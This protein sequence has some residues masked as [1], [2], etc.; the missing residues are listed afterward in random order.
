MITGVSQ[1]FRRAMNSGS[2]E[3]S[4]ANLDRSVEQMVEYM[5]FVDEAPLHDPVKGVSTFTETFPKRGPRDRQGRSLRD[6]DLQHR[7]FRYPLSYMIYSPIF[8]AMPAPA[9]ER[10]VRRLHEVLSGKDQSPQFAHLSA[11]DRRAI[12]EILRDTKAASF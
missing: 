12:L 10:V 8:D 4:K 11:D 7:L 1:Q 9:R 6:F 5:L 3:S 2:L